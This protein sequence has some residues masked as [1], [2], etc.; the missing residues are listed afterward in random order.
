MLR[1]A[2]W[3]SQSK[4]RFEVPFVAGHAIDLLLN[5]GKIIRM[6]LLE[7]EVQGRSG[8]PWVEPKDAE[9]LVGPKDVPTRDVPGKASRQA[10]S[11]GFGEKRFASAESLFGLFEILDVVVGSDPFDDVSV[12]VAY[13]QGAEECQR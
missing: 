12:L 1:R 5:R 11:L 4:L 9:R 8:A 6:G 10:Q 7:D 13:R 2:I 3:H